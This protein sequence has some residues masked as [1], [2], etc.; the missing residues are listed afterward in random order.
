MNIDIRKILNIVISISLLPIITSC[1]SNTDVVENKCYPLAVS[2]KDSG[3]V[4]YKNNTKKTRT[5]DN[6][7][8]TTFAKD[9]KIGLYV[10]DGSGNIQTNNLC[11][12]YDGTDW[13]YSA[14][15]T[16]YYDNTS[17]TKYYAYYPYQSTLTGTINAG[18]TDAAGFFSDVITKWSAA[19]PTDQSTQA[20]YSTAD[21]MVGAGTVGDLI[22][23]ATR[24]LTFNMSHQMGMVEINM[25]YYYLSTDAN[26]KYVPGLAWTGVTPYNISGTTYHCLVSPATTTTIAGEYA[27]MITVSTP[28]NFSQDVNVATGKYQTLNVDGGATGTSYTMKIGDYYLNDGSVIPNASTNK[29]LLAKTIGVVFDTSTSTTDQGHGWT[30]GYAMALTNASSSTFT[31]MWAGSDYQST[32]ETG[33]YGG[34]A[35]K[36]CNTYDLL[37]SNKD[38]YTETQ[39]I[40]SKYSSSLSSAH[41]AFWYALNYG[42]SNESGTTYYAAP[43]NKANSGWYLP[44]S[45]QWYDIATNLGGMSPTPQYAGEYYGEWYNQNSGNNGDAYICASNINNFLNAISG[46]TNHGYDSFYTNSSSNEYYWCSSE[47]TS[48]YAYD[49]IYSNGYLGLHGSC[50]KSDGFRVRPVIAF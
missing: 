38:G 29:Y 14:G 15:K 25:P 39:A 42:T 26:Y 35:Y 22:M 2:I 27:P 46:Y 44:S 5:A 30:H 4:S 12:T 9:D 50:D 17:T 40:N 32:D 31:C 6:G 43:T 11:L 24:P 41:P 16:I 23:N 13:N 3:F 48:D 36:D 37:S 47:Y 28:T 34:F 20:K 19:L 7:Y 18:A 1:V 10:V 33:T 49:M 8:A 21:L 45:G